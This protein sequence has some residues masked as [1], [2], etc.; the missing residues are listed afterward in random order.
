MG[1][2]MYLAKKLYIG[3]DYKK[4]KDQVKIKIKGVKQKR[5]SEIVEQVG[6]WR[7]ANAIHNWFVKNVQE[8][9][10]DCKEYHVSREQLKELLDL[11]SKVI[12]A[13]KLV[14]GKVYNGTKWTKAGKEEIY[15]DGMVIENPKVAMELL[16][17][18][19][20]CF[21]G[22]TDYDQWYFKKLEE[23]QKI[24]K[25]ALEE[26]DGDFYYQSSW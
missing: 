2:D 25:Q 15:E 3:N 19:I 23:T 1:L 11:C 20:G 9:S 7:K 26:K 18:T 14:K 16:P 22:G 4:P 13:S 24:L 6:Y 8:G 5:V 17:T 10:D 21:F 12:K